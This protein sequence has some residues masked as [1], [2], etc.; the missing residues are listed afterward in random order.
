MQFVLA[1]S[2]IIPWLG[3]AY[4][5]SCEYTCDNYWAYYWVWNMEKSVKGLAVLSAGWI[6]SEK[7]NIDAYLEQ[8]Q[9]SNGF[10]MS[11]N[12]TKS[13]HPYLTKRVFNIVNIF[14]EKEVSLP[15]R[16][17]LWILLAPFTSIWF[18]VIIIY[19]VYF[20][21]IMASLSWLWKL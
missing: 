3:K 4:S 7:I 6:Y 9:S 14:W 11:L 16:N 17:V 15:K 12:E 8:A 20:A 10:W 18:W 1:P 19:V 13:T 21:I 2:R 5:K